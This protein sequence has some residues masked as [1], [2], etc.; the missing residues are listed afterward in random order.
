MK[1]NQMELGFL[2]VS[3]V[4][5][6]VLYGLA[7]GQERTIKGTVTTNQ[8]PIAGVVV[9]QEGNN[10]VTTTNSS[11][12]Y[13]YKI[14]GNNA[15]LIFKHPDYSETR[16]EVGEQST[17]NIHLQKEK[18]RDEVVL[19]A[20]YYQVKD[21]ERT[22]NISK[23]SNK[24]LENQPVINVLS[25]AQGRIS[26]VSIVQNSG[27]PGGGFD[28]QIRGKNSLRSDGSYPL[29]IVD[30]IPLNAQNNSISTLSSGMLSKGESSPL[31]S[32]NPNDIES[33]E[34]LKDA[35]ATAIYGSRGA[36]GVVLIT[37]KRGKSQR[38]SAELLLNTSVSKANQFITFAET[39]QYLQMRQDA[40]RL[41]NIT[42][43]PATAYD[44]NGKWDSQRNTNW[45]KTL[46]G[47]PYLNMQQQLTL[48]SGSEQTQWYL[49]IHRQEQATPF[50]KDYG[51][52]RKGFNLNMVH[53]SA[54]QKFSISPT[55]YYT[56]QD[57]NLIERDL[58]TQI[59]LS[60][61]APALYTSTGAVNWE[62]NTFDNPISKLENQYNS[63]LKTLSAQVNARY[64]LFPS[65]SL[66][67]N[68]GYTQ[69]LQEEE[70]S[71]PSTAYNP[72]LNYTSTN[73]IIY[74][75]NVQRNSWIAEPQITWS[76][77]W[78][79]H[80]VNTLIGLTLEEKNDHLLRLQGSDFASNDLLQNIS[81]A[82]VQKVN[83]DTRVQY[84]Y[85]AFYGRFNYDYSGKYLINLTARRDGSSRFGANN[86][87]A[88]FGAIGAAWIFSKENIIQNNETLKKL[89][90]FGKLRA[91]IGTAGSDL[92]GD[93]Q[94]LDTYTTAT[95]LY[96]GVVGMYPSR[97]YNPNFSWEKTTKLEAALELGLL[98]ERININFSWYRNRSSNQL[99]GVPLAATT[100][101]LSLQSNF[102][103]KVQNTGIEAELSA[104][105]YK[106][107]S[108]KWEL[109]A[110][111]SLPK[112]KL[113]EYD[114]L[115]SS[116]YANT[117]VVGQPMNIKKVYEYKGVDPVTGV[118]Q[119]SD[120]NGD[121]KLDT[122]DRQKVAEIGVKH[123]GG[124]SNQFRYQNL[125][126]SFLVQWVKQRQY[127]M[128]Y[129][130]SLLGIQRNIPT[131][132]LDYWTPENTE[133]RYQRP[134]TGGNSAALTA[135]SRY[136]SSDA[137]IVD[138]S[139]IRLN[140]VQLSYKI[141][142]KAKGIESLTLIGQGQN[143]VTITTYKGIDP[144]GVGV[145]LPSMKTYSITAILKF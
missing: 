83:E 43:Y 91:S 82:K 139:F 145:Y 24:Q 35:D 4:A 85:S 136:T 137:V 37:T 53:H 100:G 25:A 34:V 90:S 113:L 60:P 52:E 88:N 63:E 44:V 28:I 46:I 45:F 115:S 102:P 132:M 7:Q 49:S 116:S 114:N 106:N 117:Y 127:S 103:A 118:Y 11:G 64:Q 129:N 131:Y 95:L 84:R 108:F 20:G 41:D 57:N 130:L 18:Q 140:N 105:I 6:M 123:F 27:A 38:L 56:L 62:D 47:K 133:A 39:P 111:F 94:Y 33:F 93:Y 9:S 17:L 86:R 124:I 75:G 2:K 12:Q 99:V 70:R 74:L 23:L 81:N 112:S 125:S 87:F 40:Y 59:I 15:I 138:A 144:E 32:I 22:G 54:D 73:S 10:S 31:N 55:I 72:S 48:S 8:K 79:K 97:L 126:L 121:G 50:G 29:I 135:F 143:L 26:G 119:F 101:F 92:I 42:N 77:E 68:A 96:D 142:L 51:Y 71:N 69:T 36:N 89:L 3:L 30:G 66:K 13:Q 120:M 104:S 19:N 80:H 14:T 98:K 122:N 134:T 107:T 128:D 110:N 65:I 21:K 58:S 76:K 5:T 61:N 109:S 1:K 78:Q 16:V 67:L 141:P